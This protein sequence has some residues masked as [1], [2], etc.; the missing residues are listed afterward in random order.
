[1]APGRRLELR[2]FRGAAGALRGRG[3][4]GPG[5]GSR[6]GGAGRAVVPRGSAPGSPS[7]QLQAPPPATF[8]Q[9]RETG[10]PRPSYC[11]DTCQDSGVRGATQPS[12]RVAAGPRPRSPARRRASRSS[13]ERRRR[14]EETGCSGRDC[15]RGVRCSAGSRASRRRQEDSP[16]GRGGRAAEP[17]KVPHLEEEDPLV[18]GRRGAEGGCARPGARSGFSHLCHQVSAAE[19]RGLRES[20]GAG[21]GAHAGLPFRCPLG[22]HRPTATTP[23]PPPP[24]HPRRTQDADTSTLAFPLLQAGLPAVLLGALVLNLASWISSARVVTS[25]YYRRLLR[26]QCPF[27]FSV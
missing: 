12:L 2:S 16:R 18:G 19:L 25:G 13:R 6:S 22:A 15:G 11:L 23:S 26:P 8:P 9:P 24:R 4:S 3:A 5:P 21:T 14:W 17:G 27:V 10:L 7:E 20:R 1:M